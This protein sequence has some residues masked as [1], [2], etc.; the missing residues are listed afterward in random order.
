M[1]QS[2]KHNAVFF[3][4]QSSLVRRVCTNNVICLIVNNVTVAFLFFRVCGTL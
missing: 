1:R 3:E 4:R 2:L